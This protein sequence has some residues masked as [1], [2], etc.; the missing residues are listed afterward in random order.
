MSAPYDLTGASSGALT[1]LREAG[2][3][4]RRIVCSCACGKEVTLL[5][6]NFMS[7][8]TKSCGCWRRTTGG[9]RIDLTGMVFGRLTVEA[10]SRSCPNHRGAYWLCRCSCG[11]TVEVLGRNLR[12]GYTKSCGCWRSDR[13]SSGL[14]KDGRN[15]WSKKDE[16]TT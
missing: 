1:Y 4:P 6:S 15:Q 14:N 12:A 10:W 2:S 5:A 7:G 8:N 3:A 11:E 16:Q 13:A 9:R